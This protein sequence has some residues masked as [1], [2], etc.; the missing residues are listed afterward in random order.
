M[1]GLRA[2]G[3]KQRTSEFVLGVLFLVEVLRATIFLERISIL[4]I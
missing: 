1:T 2:R 3:R 4:K